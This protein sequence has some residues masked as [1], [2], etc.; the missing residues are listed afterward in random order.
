MLRRK[1]LIVS[2]LLFTCLV[3]AGKDKK[4]GLLPADVLQ[5][6]TVVVLVD[7]HADVDVKDPNAS[8]IAREN[9]ERALVNWGRFS[10]TPDRWH[11]DL[12]IT[13]WKGN[14][15]VAQPG[16]GGVP[17]NNRPV[18][19]QPNSSGGRPG[20][21]MGNPGS[22]GN[23]GGLG[24]PSDSEPSTPHPEV[25][26]GGSQDMFVVYRGNNSDSG[27]GNPL[28]APPVWRY[29]AIDALQAPNVPAVEQFQKLITASEKQQ[30]TK[31]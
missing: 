11:A 24:D 15:K 23:P 12:I 13:V 20:G 30:G 3:A 27:T 16:I 17:M 29:S 14:G 26:L 18:G 19:L 7:P 25:E 28:D 31:P 22:A 9:V 4:K 1:N 10:I 6:R 5:A 21:Q 8:Q 2:V